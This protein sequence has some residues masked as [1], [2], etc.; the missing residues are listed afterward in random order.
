MPRVIEPGHG[1]AITLDELI[2]ALEHEKWDAR[3]ED[4][5]AAIGPWLARLGRN[6]RFLADL[7]IAELEQRFSGQRD[8]G[9]GAQVMMLSPPSRRY[10]VRAAFWPARHDAVVKAGGTAPFF[11]DLPHDHNFSFLTVGYTGPGYW[12]DYYLF[13]GAQDAQPGDPAR[14]VF[15]RRARLEPGRLM[16]YRAH[17]DVHVQL[18]PDRFSVSLNI[19]GA[20]PAQA[21]RTQYRFDTARDIVAQAMTTTGSEALVTLATRLGGDAGRALAADL[22]IRHPHPR[23]RA[24]AL[25][26]L[27]GGALPF[28]AMHPLAERALDDASPLVRHVARH[29]LAAVAASGAISDAPIVS[30]C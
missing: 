25:T 16:L 19:L 20:T 12:S 26:A 11:Y 8:S 9:Y 28:D 22:A 17:R 21:W 14:L 13:D 27:A 24:T 1:A 5:F 7:A 15:D 10:A 6:R 29:A 18:P 3:D 30:G 2:E 4:A 23:M